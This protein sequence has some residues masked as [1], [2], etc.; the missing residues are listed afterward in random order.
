MFGFIT[1]IKRLW[2]ATMA[3]IRYDK[4][5]YSNIQVT[6]KIYKSNIAQ[7]VYQ[8]LKQF[9][10]WI[11]IPTLSG[12]WWWQQQFSSW[13]ME[14]ST[15]P[16]LTRRSAQLHQWYI[17][18]ILAEISIV[19]SHWKAKALRKMSLNWDDVVF[20]KITIMTLFTWHTDF[21]FSL[22]LNVTEIV[23]QVL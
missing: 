16:G 5:W 11:C 14:A 19:L 9:L 10:D 22:S 8:Y 12:R 3:T 4:N 1:H 17:H 13:H 21:I 7:S 2:N 18:K 23:W 6:I 15:F 20:I